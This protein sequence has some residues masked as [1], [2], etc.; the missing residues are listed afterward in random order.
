MNIIFSHADY[1]SQCCSAGGHVP[2]KSALRGDVWRSSHSAHK[3]HDPLNLQ[4]QWCYFHLWSLPGNCSTPDGHC[5]LLAGGRR[6]AGLLPGVKALT[7]CQ[8]CTGICSNRTSMN[9][10]STSNTK[11]IY[12]PS[13]GVVVKTIFPCWRPITDC[14]P[15]HSNLH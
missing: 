4:P 2:I 9:S 10:C 6:A 5:W 7:G 8:T 3:R 12:S 14:Y 1:S 11:S 15:L 13:L